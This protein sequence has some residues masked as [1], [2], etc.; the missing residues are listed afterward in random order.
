MLRCDKHILLLSLCATAFYPTTTCLKL[1]LHFVFPSIGHK[2]NLWVK[3]LTAHLN[4]FVRTHLTSFRFTHILRI[5]NTILPFL[6]TPAIFM[7]RSCVVNFFY[8]L[9][10]C[11]VISILPQ[12]TIFKALFHSCISPPRAPLLP[13]AAESKPVLFFF[14]ILKSNNLI[15]AYRSYQLSS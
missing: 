10:N 5:K 14:S 6:P 7:E 12:L 15:L 8:M 13:E 2:S 9:S 1:K 11:L 4:Q 3:E